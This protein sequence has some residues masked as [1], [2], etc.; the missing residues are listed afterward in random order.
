[1]L[2]R[3]YIIIGLLAIIILAGAFVA[4][5]FIH[6]GDYRGRMEQLAT[7]M[8]G[9][10]VTIRGEIDFSLLPR[11]RL[12]LADVLVGSPE[13]PAATVDT[14]EAEFSLLDFL[15]DNY[16]VTKLVLVAPVVDFSLDES[17]FFGSGVTVAP[18]GNTVGLSQATIQNATLRLMDRRS[19]ETFVADDV[20]G[21]LKITSFAGP[22]QFQGS[23]FYQNTRYGVRFN[24]SAPD[25]VGDT[26]A[27]G[28]ITGDGFSLTA[29][30]LLTPGMAPKFDGALVY[31]QTPPPS[32]AADDIRGDLVLESRMTGSTDRI[33]LSGYTLQPDENRAGTRLTGAASI[34]LGNRR[35][36]DAV[37]SG[38]VFSLPPRDANEDA[39]VQPYELVRLLGELPAPLV[40]P[41]Q[42]RVGIDLAEIGLRGF[43]L[44]DVRVDAMTDGSDWEVEQFIAQ[45]PGGTEMRASGRLGND[46]GDTVFN[47]RF[48]VVS[49]RLDGLA[50]LWRKPDE[51][52]VLFNQPGK[53]EGEMLLGSDAVG[54]N[55]GM[56]TLAGSTHALELRLGFGEERRLDV[57]GHF[58]ALD[59]RGSALVAALLPNI[60]A[61]PG[62]GNS[63]PDGSFSLTGERALLLGL[64]GQ[65]LKAEGYWS[66]G[67]ITFDRFVAA[68]W[69]GA[70]LDTS[71]RLAGTAQAPQISGSGQFAIADAAAPALAALY[72]LGG[73]PEGWREALARSAPADVLLDLSIPQESGAQVLTL[74]GALG[75]GEV[76]L[77]AELGL[78]LAGLS[79]GQLRLTASL[80][81]N[82]PAGLSQQLGL[83]AEGI[84][85]GE[86][87]LVSL[88][89]QGVPAEGLRGSI[90]ASSDDESIG[91]TGDLR[92]AA[93][94]ELQ[95]TGRIDAILADAGTVAQIVGAT[96]L[97]LPAAEGSAELHFEGNRIVRLSAIAGTS[98]ESGFSGDLSLSRTGQTAAVAG[99]IALDT[100]SAE[101]LATALFGPAAL[102]P[103][104]PVWSDGPIS[105]GDE[106]RATRGTVTVKAGAVTAG[107]QPRLGAT[108]FEL[109]WDETEL[110]LGRF[111]AALGEGSASLDLTVCCA[112]PLADKTIK[113]RLGLVNVAIADIATSAAAEKVGGR[114]DGGVQFEATGASLADAIDV[115][116]GDGSFTI[117]DFN[118]SSLAPSVFPTIAGL[119]DVLDT[120]ADALD[121]LIGLALGQGSFT[122]PSAAGAFTIAGGVAR[123][124][125]FIVEGD[126]GRLAGDIN[127]ALADLGLDGSFVLTPIGFDDPNGLVR[128]DTARIVTR[129]AGT[130]L[131]PDVA[132][133][134][135]EMVAAI[136]VRA[137][138]L[139]VDRLEALRIED[140]ERQRAAADERNRL[141][142]AQR[143][144]AAAEA[145]RL[146]AEQEAAQQQAEAERLEEERLAR[147]LQ[148]QQQ[149]PAQPPITPAPAPN[150]PF[151][152]SFQP[153]VNQP[154]GPPVNQPL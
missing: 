38:G 91:Y 94:G 123:L 109:S 62:F 14:V 154:L 105:V 128:S 122:A 135:A 82:D 65:E 20:D 68:D 32:E 27:T 25:A 113:G 117:A 56:L 104:A 29:E 31:R 146:A 58:D 18:Q 45:L 110:R 70:A 150:G 69:G 26:R 57:V 114:L 108:S 147:E 138:E 30:G 136:Q 73:L 95:G 7:T 13:E 98:G 15:R 49:E 141:I 75:S 86:S 66:P 42:G 129:L 111:E 119:E 41:M 124:T 121:A 50:Q 24:S 23:A 99:A 53:L 67:V 127:L 52:N 151:D 118:V 36:F 72:D 103:G 139:E 16:I 132:L 112:G 8:L 120:D 4:P 60:P 92:L 131:M 71:L 76:N 148:L 102:L 2:N 48:S 64:E 149:P 37:V 81:S 39:S 90:N 5:R 74:G 1:V 89:L 35:S 51:N 93:E 43:A 40:P 106:V 145:A 152:F 137:N 100:A 3:I 21:E 142:E 34:Q 83:D 88:G 46:N 77:R 144:R 107:G 78:G 59:N 79:T 17:G 85:Q 101:G 11:P 6:W 47:G 10:P 63:F 55:N 9:T 97:S 12:Q 80:D 84:F 87:L 28:A 125:N 44:R 33:V 133:D 19:G 130:L 140:A 22:F 61:E 54:I 126:S 143:Q 115:L 96:G 153:Q 134:L 116:A